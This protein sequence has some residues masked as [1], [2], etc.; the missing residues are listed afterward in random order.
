MHYK[1]LFLMLSIATLS[2]SGCKKSEPIDQSTTTVVIETTAAETTTVAETTVEEITTA[3]TTAEETTAE[4]TTTAAETTTAETTTA[5]E[6]TV[7]ETVTST[8]TESSS[9]QVDNSYYT[10]TYAEF[11]VNGQTVS[12]TEAEWD[13]LPDDHQ[14]AYIAGKT[15]EEAIA[16]TQKLKDEAPGVAAGVTQE[17]ID[18]FNK[19]NQ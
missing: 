16:E 10:E 5:A 19:S 13:A 3:E 12:F 17:E 7:E 11:V 14:M 8:I 18:A 4:E 2:L 1:K 9:S 15:P 6:T